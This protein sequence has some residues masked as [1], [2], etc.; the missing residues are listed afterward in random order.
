[1]M[2]ALPASH[3]T[4]IALWR[5][6][7]RSSQM[8][9]QQGRPDE[10]PAVPSQAPDQTPPPPVKKAPA[11]AAKK[12]PARRPRPRRL[13]RRRPPPRRPPRQEGPGEPTPPAEAAVP[14][15]RPRLRSRPR[16]RSPTPTARSGQHGR[17][18]DCRPG[19]VDGGQAGD[20]V[21]CP[22]PGPPRSNL[23]VAAAIAAGVLAIL[24]VLL[25][26]RGSDDD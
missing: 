24:V 4:P 2:G 7:Q 8:A 17:Q 9:D 23:P 16:R 26:R 18:G 10:Q 21:S 22:Q 25:A 13:R 20:P 11:K 1:M 12:A 15:R 3:R 19:E 5:E 14:P 6:L